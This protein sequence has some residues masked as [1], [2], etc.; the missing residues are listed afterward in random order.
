MVFDDADKRVGKLAVILTDLVRV[1]DE[2]MRQVLIADRRSDSV[3]E[4]GRRGRK[5]RAESSPFL[6]PT[7]SE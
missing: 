6:F 7:R 1:Y 5:R 2:V 3:G 4:G